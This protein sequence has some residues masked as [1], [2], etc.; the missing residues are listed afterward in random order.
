VAA[1]IADAS[2]ALATARK[3]LDSQ[4]RAMRRLESP[5]DDSERHRDAEGIR[6]LLAYSEGSMPGNCGMVASHAF[7]QSST[8]FSHRHKIGGF[9]TT[10]LALSRAQTR[11]R[12]RIEQCCGAATRMLGYV[13]D[14]VIA[15]VSELMKPDISQR[16]NPR[17]CE[18]L[19][20]DLGNLMA[21]QRQL[22][23]LA[24]EGRVLLMPTPM[25]LAN[26][27]MA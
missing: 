6:A 27:E 23:A 13:D 4:T 17:R 1:A 12:K 10:I 15:L 2:G 11:H 9:G 3:H 26:V 20:V 19:S 16:P 22:Q 14:A 21:W 18:V 5:L 24:L 25:P 8:M 7:A